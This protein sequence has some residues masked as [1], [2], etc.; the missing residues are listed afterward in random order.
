MTPI[1]ELQQDDVVEFIRRHPALELNQMLPGDLH[2]TIAYYE[3]E[4]AL[5]LACDDGLLTGLGIGYQCHYGD[6]DRPWPTPTR[7]G[8]CFYI[9]LVVADSPAAG[10]AVWTQWANR[11]RAVKQLKIYAKRHHKIRRVTMREVDRMVNYWRR[12]ATPKE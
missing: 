10:L 3:R 7:S 9:A 1:I 11:I 6:W 4:R 8:E 2:D 5:F 12:S